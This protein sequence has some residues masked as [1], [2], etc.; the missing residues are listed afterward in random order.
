MPKCVCVWG[1]SGAQIGR[2]SSSICNSMCVFVW[3]VWGVCG[4][5]RHARM[6]ALMQEASHSSGW[7]PLSQLGSETS[8]RS[9]FWNKKVEHKDLVCMGREVIWNI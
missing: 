4:G 3:E 5:G 8:S 6:S 7:N 2:V 1:N 9:H